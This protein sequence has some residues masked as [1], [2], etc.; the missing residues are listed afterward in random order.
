MEAACEKQ[1][2][3]TPEH[4][5]NVEKCVSDY[6][7]QIDTLKSHKKVECDR[8]ADGLEAALDCATSLSC[9]EQKDSTNEQTRKCAA[10]YMKVLEA[11]SE[12]C[13]AK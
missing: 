5:N 3:C 8:L 9:E 7:N 13:N 1:K 2:E 4:Y 11:N 12:A 6:R 10:D